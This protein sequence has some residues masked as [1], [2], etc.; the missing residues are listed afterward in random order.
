[1]FRLLRERYNPERIIFFGSLGRDQIHE[2]S[3]LD[4]IVVKKSSLPFLKPIEE[5]L[6]FIK[7]QVSVDIFVY[8]PEEFERLCQERLF[9]REE[10]LAKGKTVYER[11]G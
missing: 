9:F 3:D 11:G 10:V 2:W 1:M 4:L 8:T 6:K 5:V 7:P